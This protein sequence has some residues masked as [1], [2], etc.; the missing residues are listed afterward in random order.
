MD[1]DCGQGASVTRLEKLQIS[2]MSRLT[3]CRPEHASFLTTSVAVS[4][5]PTNETAQF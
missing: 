2:L 3:E 1:E 5:Q 4:L